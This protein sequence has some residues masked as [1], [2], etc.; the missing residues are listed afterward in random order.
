MSPPASATALRVDDVLV[1]VAGR[2]EHV[3]QRRAG[4]AER[5]RSAGAPRSAAR[6]RAIRA[7]HSSRIALPDRLLVGLLERVELE[8]AGAHP[9]GDLLRRAPGLDQRVAEP[10]ARCRGRGRRALARGRRARSAAAPRA[11]PRR[12]RRAAA[13][14]CARPTRS[15]ARRSARSPARRSAAPPGGR[16]AITPGVEAELGGAH[17]R[18]L[19]IGKGITSRSVSRSVRIIT[20]RSTPMPPPAVGE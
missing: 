11:R 1:H 16:P 10:V 14:R 19:T 20:S 7:E 2:G 17:E 13:S 9:L 15:S 18:S 3:S 6:S 4:L 8:L 12:R 5:S